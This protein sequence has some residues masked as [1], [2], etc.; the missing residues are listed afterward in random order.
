MNV[1]DLLSLK[2]KII[3]VTG[4]AG[5]YGKCIVEGLAEADGTVITA[6]RNLE[7]NEAFVNQLK[8]KGLNVYAQQL[9][10][11]DPA[12]VRD[13]KAA[14]EKQFGALH[15][16]VNNA[17]ARPMATYDAPIEAFAE[18]MRVN[19]TGMVDLMRE[20][21][22]MII[23]NGGGS[24]INIASM[25]GMFGPDLSNYEGT[26]MTQSPPPDYYFHNA[27]LINLTRYWARM[28][29]GKNVRVNCVSPGGLLNNQPERFLENYTK[30]VPL[31]RMANHDDI[32]GLVVLLASEA[33]AYING[34]NILM[35]GGLNA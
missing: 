24:I 22:D 31:G 29:R 35:D 27:G 32:K 33:G 1:K 9:D 19:A 15:V 34:E 7:A 16:F 5:N 28:M 17:V 20:I 6:S 8:E 13:L 10:Q 2:G 11:G 23:K 25:M 4:G 12:S 26:T 3:L 30:K 21:T 18:S 14:I